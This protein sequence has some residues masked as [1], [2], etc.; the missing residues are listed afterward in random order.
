MNKIFFT[1]LIIFSQQII[2]QEALGEYLE[3]EC[4]TYEYSEAELTKFERN[5]NRYTSQQEVQRK[6]G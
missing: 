1:L 4:P 5:A 3:W 2:S 6:P